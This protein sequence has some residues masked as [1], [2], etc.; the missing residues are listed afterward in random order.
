MI[1]FI[2]VCLCIDVMRL[3]F[4]CISSVFHNKVCDDNRKPLSQ[5]ILS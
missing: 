5:I 4:I 1:F 3:F 2:D